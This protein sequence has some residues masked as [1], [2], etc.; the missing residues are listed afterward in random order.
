M[1]RDFFTQI[2]ITKKDRK[3]MAGCLALMVVTPIWLFLEGIRLCAII[4]TG[5]Y[6]I[7]IRILMLIKNG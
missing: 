7:M 4:L 2:G 3:E 5:I 6:K 1:T